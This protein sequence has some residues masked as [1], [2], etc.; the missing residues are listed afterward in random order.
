MKNINFIF[1]GIL[2]TIGIVAVSGCTSQSSTVTIQNM[3][4]NPST[5]HITGSTTIIWINKDNIEHEVVSDTGLF[6]S[7]V[8]APGESFN[9]TFNQA[10]DY[11]YHCAIH[12]SMVG[13]IVVSSSSMVNSTNNSSTSTVTP[14]PSSPIPSSPGNNP[15]P[16]NPA[17]A[18]SNPGGSGTSGLGY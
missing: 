1:L 18:P 11:A 2:L 15:A 12:P 14:I 17:P 6:D 5:V 16:N 10:G 7:G 8:L 3:A 4:F 13:I 9:Y